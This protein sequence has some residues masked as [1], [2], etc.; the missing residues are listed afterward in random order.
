MAEMLIRVTPKMDKALKK[1]DSAE[2]VKRCK[3]IQELMLETQ[4]LNGIVISEV[5]KQWRDKSA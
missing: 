1:L 5:Y 2:T 4:M 3:S